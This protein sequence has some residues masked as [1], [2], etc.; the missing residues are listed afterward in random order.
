MYSGEYDHNYFILVLL[1]KYACLV[2]AIKTVMQFDVK[3][4]TY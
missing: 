1:T 2:S 3:R 4:A